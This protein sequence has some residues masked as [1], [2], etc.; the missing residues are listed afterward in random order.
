MPQRSSPGDPLIRSVWR[1]FCRPLEPEVR[2][3]IAEAR[4]RL[5]P[6]LRVDRQTVGR[7]EE[8]C[9]ATI[10]VMPRCDFGCVG[11]YLGSNANRAR[12]LPLAE[13][14]HQM[15]LLRR[16]LGLWGNLQLTDG[17]VLL[18]PVAEV[19]ELMRYAREVRL[20]PMLMT[21]GDHF[22]RR[23]GLLERLMVQGGLVELCIHID[24]TQRGRAGR[25]YRDA[26]SESDLMPLR[27]EFADMIRAAR[28]T[29]KR[30]LRVATSVTVTRRN[31]PEV[32]D[33]VRW[34]VANADAFRIVSF[35]PAAPV[36]RTRPGV[37]AGVGM[38]ALWR[39]IAEGLGLDDDLVR[40]GQWW[41]GHPECSRLI[42]GL[43]AAQRGRD[44]RYE[45]VATSGLPADRRFLQRFLDH[46]GGISFRA[47]RRPQIAARLAGMMR[48]HPGFFLGTFPRFVWSMLRRLDPDHRVRLA[49]RLLTGS[50]RVHP[51]SIGSHHFMSASE[52]ATP[53]GRQRLDNCIF[54]AAV[55]GRLLSMC[56]INATG[57]RDRFY[58]RL[59]DSRPGTP[60]A[61]RLG[62]TV[63]AS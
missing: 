6:Q 18:R 20:V 3:T 61:A 50:A 14:R 48:Q 34:A 23:P 41:F 43:V 1:A 37:G 26:R 16:R 46:W 8:G 62:V 44:N 56:E 60:Q 11:C 63:G 38:E 7:Q 55:D 19:I 17:E 36:G 27:D 29:T 25:A 54:H 33:I 47:D 13:V 10:G 30:P 32:G 49:C 39:R 57:I 21:H 31:L 53:G 59:I 22:R 45:L 12:A 24:T 15:R 51:L 42:T 28:S 4:Q 35:Q 52:M 9:G 40:A 58:D 2:R 5:S